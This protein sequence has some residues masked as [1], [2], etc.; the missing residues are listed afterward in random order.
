MERGWHCLHCRCNCQ[1]MLVNRT[2]QRR[3]IT[4]CSVRPLPAIPQAH[5]FLEPEVQLTQCHKS[6][7]GMKK[8]KCCR[9]GFTTIMQPRFG[10]L[11][12]CFFGLNELQRCQKGFGEKGPMQVFPPSFSTVTNQLHAANCTPLHIPLLGL[13][14]PHFDPFA[15]HSAPCFIFQHFNFQH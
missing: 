6:R 2:N 4:G 9:N 14:S 12:S 15:L 8:K 1:H 11:Q 13:S 7:S 3:S 5:G 10:L